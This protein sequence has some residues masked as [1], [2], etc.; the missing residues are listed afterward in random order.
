MGSKMA[1][2]RKHQHA[3]RVRSANADSVVYGLPMTPE[4]LAERID[5]RHQTRVIPSGKHRG[6]R[7]GNRAKALK[8]FQ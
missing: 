2:K 6:T 7:S 8:E 1:K 4:Q 3:H 5:G